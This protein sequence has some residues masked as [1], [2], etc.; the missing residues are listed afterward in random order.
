[1]KSEAQE[2]IEAM[3]DSTSR[4]ASGCTGRG[5][6]SKRANGASPT[7]VEQVAKLTE[8]SNKRLERVEKGSSG[9]EARRDRRA[10]EQYDELEAEGQWLKPELAG[11]RPNSANTVYVQP[12]PEAASITAASR[13]SRARSVR[14]RRPRQKA[15]EHS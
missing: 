13:R 2:Q 6:A 8:A 4:A 12:A 14:P 10:F 9:R 5:S 15:H 11:P 7:L 3:L 1:M